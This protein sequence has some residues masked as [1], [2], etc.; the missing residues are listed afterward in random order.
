MVWPS[1]GASSCEARFL[2]FDFFPGVKSLAMEAD[3]VVVVEEGSSLL[4]SSVELVVCKGWG[5]LC[6]DLGC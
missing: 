4:A 5:F 2:L 1:A 6:A 3:V